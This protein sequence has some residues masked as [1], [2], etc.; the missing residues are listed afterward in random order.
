MNKQ[1]DGWLNSAQWFTVLLRVFPFQNNF[2][3][4]YPSCKTNLDLWD[5]FGRKKT[6]YS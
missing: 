1:T 3:E 6:F 2:K 5:C 4:L